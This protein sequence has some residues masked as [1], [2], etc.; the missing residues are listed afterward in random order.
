MIGKVSYYV[1]VLRPESRWVANLISGLSLLMVMWTTLLGIIFSIRFK[2]YP[3][4]FHE[5]TDKPTEHFI[6]AMQEKMA[7]PGSELPTSDGDGKTT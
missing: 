6:K 5:S 4:D 2:F 1:F 3:A 7:E